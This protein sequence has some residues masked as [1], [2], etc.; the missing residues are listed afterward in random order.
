MNPC[1]MMYT[2]IAASVS[3]DCLISPCLTW[4][5]S[6]GMASLTCKHFNA[7]CY[8]VYLVLIYFSACCIIVAYLPSNL[9]LPIVVS[10]GQIN[11]LLVTSS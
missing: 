8:R 9:C 1:S 4:R 7:N 6:R 11:E 10:G 5:M 2:L 3:P